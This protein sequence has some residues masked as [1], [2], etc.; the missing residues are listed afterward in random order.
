MFVPYVSTTG[1][2]HLAWKGG[3][4]ILVKSSSIDK[5][6]TVHTFYWHFTES[7][8]APRQ[9]PTSSTVS[10]PATPSCLLLLHPLRCRCFRLRECAQAWILNVC[11]GS[12]QMA[13]K[14]TKARVGVEE[15][16]LVCGVRGHP[17]SR[18]L[19]QPRRATCT[20]TLIE[21]FKQKL[22]K[23]FK[24]SYPHSIYDCVA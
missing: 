9:F 7:P 3:N 1:T 15:R 4:K 20:K 5:R 24:N 21:N 8:L 22:L 23:Y 16:E 18:S 19:T 2:K 17:D 12:T 11:F 6:Q 10:Y 13:S 14:G